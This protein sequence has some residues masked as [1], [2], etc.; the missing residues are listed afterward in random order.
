MDF[1]RAPS[2][3][4]EGQWI[5]GSSV[6]L[7]SAQFLKDHVKSA[8]NLSTK[9]VKRTFHLMMSVTQSGIHKDWSITNTEFGQG[10]YGVVKYAQNRWDGR[11]AAVKILPKRDAWGCDKTKIIE[12]EISLMR[13]I[14]HPNCIAMYGHYQSKSHVY[15]VMEPVTGGQLLER[16]IAKDH[17]SE[18]EAAHCFIQ[19]IG[20]VKYL[21]QI[22][23]V[24]RD[25]KVLS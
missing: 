4:K 8:R 25:L 17:Y 14:E 5:Q 16:I 23:I 3:G 20:A 15:I 21:H 7:D 13:D 11:P 1:F 12:E 24:H 18:T 6:L 9:S 19:I 2:E 22:G 10:H